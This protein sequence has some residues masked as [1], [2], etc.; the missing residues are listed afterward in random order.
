M[1]D[2]RITM[3]DNR[4]TMNDNRLHLIPT[5]LIIALS[6]I[7]CNTLFEIDHTLKPEEYRK[8]GMPDHKKLWINDDYIN[9]NITLSSLKMNDPLS[10]PRK[11]SKKSGELFRR[12]VN[13]ENLSFIHDTI[14]PLRTRAY[15]I[16]YF[17]QFQTEMEQ[18]YT[19]EYKGKNFYSEELLDIHIFGLV[20]HDRM[21]ELGWM[22]E[23]SDDEDVEGIKSGMQ[24]V[25][26]NYMKLMPRLL[27]ELA[28]TDLYSVDDTGR[29]A[30]AIS[31]SITKNNV[32][33]TPQEKNNLVSEFKNAIENSRSSEVRSSLQDCIELLNR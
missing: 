28:K 12:M 32:W 25:K 30:I 1:N 7:S 17:P 26:Y 23:R 27:G 29:L 11:N 10:L 16:Q 31:S 9:A 19:I 13:E 2:N 33:M 22:I 8:L 24:A 4:I 20:I 21:L 18:L 6:F 14:F 3:N 5:L 15:T